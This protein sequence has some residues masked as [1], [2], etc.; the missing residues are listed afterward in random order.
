MYLRFKWLLL[1]VLCTA[2]YQAKANNSDTCAIP[3]ALDSN[4]SVLYWPFGSGKYVDSKGWGS[5]GYGYGQITHFGSDYYAMDWSNRLVPTCDSPFY[6]PLNGEVILV[7][8]SCQT[9]CTPSAAL[10]G[11]YGNQIII[12]STDNPAYF[13][14]VAHLATVNVHQGKMV[15]AGDLIGTI[16]STGNSTGPHAHVALYRNT[17]IFLTGINTNFNG[18]VPDRF[19]TPF[20]FGAVCQQVTAVTDNA[21]AKQIRIYPNPASHQ[22]YIAVSDPLVAR[23]LRW[24]LLDIHGRIL[25]QDVYR[26]QTIIA[27]S[28]LP[29]GMYFIRC[30]Q[31]KK[32]SLFKLLVLH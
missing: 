13:F 32:T 16:G 7:N 25:Q 27:V 18:G 17:D 9:H 26:Q 21:L 2:L 23:Q 19:A 11:A 22:V 6:A 1:L 20:T 3:F 15:K 29:R 4:V 5:Y 28:R 12:R 14:R 8:G 30:E 10:C 24:T 31:G